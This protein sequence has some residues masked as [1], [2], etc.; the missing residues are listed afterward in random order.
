MRKHVTRASLCSARE[1]SRKII[2]LHFNL[3]LRTT[4]SINTVY[5][6]FHCT[7]SIVYMGVGGGGGYSRGPLCMKP[8]IESFWG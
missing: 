2:E 6:L 4:V 5:L 3:N 1:K 7:I 8:C